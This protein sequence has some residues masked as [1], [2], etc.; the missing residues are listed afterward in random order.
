MAYDSASA[1]Q[2]AR[3]DR[4]Q[5]EALRIS[6]GAM[7]GTSLAVLQAH[8]GEMPLQLRRLKSQIEYSIKVRCRDGHV[9]SSV[10][11]E[12]WIHHYGTYNDRNLPIAIKVADFQCSGS[13]DRSNPTVARGPAENC[14]SVVKLHQ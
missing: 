3:L 14:R 9:S 11:D 7:R 6:T 10:F 1:T 2:L 13:K 4:I 12:H 8:C 5:C